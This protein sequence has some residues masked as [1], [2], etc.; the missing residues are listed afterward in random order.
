[1]GPIGLMLLKAAATGF[2]IARDF[3]KPKAKGGELPVGG[4][5]ECGPWISQTICPPTAEGIHH[6]FLFRLEHDACQG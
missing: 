4:E 2:E 6:G 3:Q 1:M 5:G